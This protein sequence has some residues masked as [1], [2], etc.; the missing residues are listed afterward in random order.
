MKANVVD[1]QWYR[2]IWTLDIQ[3]LSWVEP[4]THEVDFAVKALGLRGRERI[5][6]LACG[7]GRH[8]LDLARRGCSVVGVDITAE[9]IEEARKRATDEHLRAEFI[10]ADLREMSFREEFDV[11]LNLADGAIGYFESEEENLRIFNL[12]ASALKPGGKHLMGICNGVYAVKH[13]PRR[14]WEMGSRRLSLAD[15]AWQ[16]ESSR[17]LYTAYS[18][19]YGQPLAEPG[20]KGSVSS[21]RLYTLEELRR[22]LTARGMEIDKTYGGY[23]VSI[24]ACEDRLALLVYSR[25]TSKPLSRAQ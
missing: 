6:D 12:I 7:F 18:V 5:L 3:D 8:A 2:K 25:K 20:R 15:F 17:M 1:P 10:C 23:D 21:I 19:E 24:P 22:I 13:F 14:H 9:Y 4:T 16:Q 11:V